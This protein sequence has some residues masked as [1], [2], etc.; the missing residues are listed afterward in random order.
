MGFRFNPHKVLGAVVELGFRLGR[1]GF[2]LHPRKV[3]E[4][5]V[6]PGLAVLLGNLEAVAAAAS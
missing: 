6:E 5:V 2:R 3:L 1:M 4:A